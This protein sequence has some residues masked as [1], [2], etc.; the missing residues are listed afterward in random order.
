MIFYKATL[1]TF[2]PILGQFWNPFRTKLWGQ[3][4][5]RKGQDEPKRAIRSFKETK[6]CMFKNLK[7]PLVFKGFWLQRPLKRASR[8]PR[9]L[10]KGTQ[11]N[12]RPQK[13]GPKI[14]PENYQILDKFWSPFWSP[15]AKQKKTKMDPIFGTPFPHISGVQIMPRQTINE[16]GKKAPVTEIILYKRKGGTRPYKAS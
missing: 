10:P 3:F 11:R 6:N 16:R 12:P 1:A 7:K 8:G 4:L 9:G 15:K 13:K 2:D 5:T 14:G